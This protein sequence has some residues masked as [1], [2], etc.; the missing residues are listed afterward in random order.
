MKDKST[1]LFLKENTY[2]KQ[3]PQG[4][5]FLRGSAFVSVVPC[6]DLQY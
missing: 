3:R 2:D 5:P 4:N 6:Q 1:Y